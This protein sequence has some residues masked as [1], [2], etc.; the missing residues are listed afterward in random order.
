VP[1]RFPGPKLWNAR[2]GIE[3]LAGALIQRMKQCLFIKGSGERESKFWTT[4]LPKKAER[5]REKSNLHKY[6][7]QDCPDMETK[8]NTL[9]FVVSELEEKGNDEQA[10]S[11][12]SSKASLWLPARIK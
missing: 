10:H 1:Q 8:V 12:S 2:N 4:C 9:H 5:D 7:G 6:E 11:S 3:H